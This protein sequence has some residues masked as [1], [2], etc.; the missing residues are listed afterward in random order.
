VFFAL[1]DS[2][3]TGSISKEEVLSLSESLLFLFRRE[4]GSS[5]SLAAVSNFLNVS[6]QMLDA[7]NNLN[8]NSG[9]AP[10]PK[11]SKIASR[12]KGL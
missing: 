2:E 4:K 9:E 8:F 7:E 12:K 10:S 1:Y 6:F 11:V 5:D 3:K